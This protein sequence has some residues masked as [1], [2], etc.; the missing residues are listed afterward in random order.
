[1]CWRTR[2]LHPED[3][4][5]VAAQ[6]CQGDDPGTV[7]PGRQPSESW[8]QGVGGP[9]IRQAD[10][11]TPW[12]GRSTGSAGTGRWP[13]GTT[14]A[15]SS[16]REPLM[17]PAPGSGNPRL[18][19]R[20]WRLLPGTEVMVLGRGGIKTVAEATGAHP[21]TEA[22]IGLSG[23]DPGPDP[24][25]R[26]GRQG[27]HGRR[28]GAVGRAGRP[29][30]SGDPGRPGNGIAWTTKS[31]PKLAV[32]LTAQGDNVSATTVAKPARQGQRRGRPRWPSAV[33]WV[34]RPT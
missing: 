6:R 26:C 19:Q 23:A 15:S 5:C 31:T 12:S 16:T 2:P 21:D 17:S 25:S 11:A 22:G 24:P 27:C 33:P 4:G 7:E 10:P 3:W 14:N 9:E 13:P 34:L 18:D 28:P 30:G 29:G 32:E 20:A 8:F 1:V